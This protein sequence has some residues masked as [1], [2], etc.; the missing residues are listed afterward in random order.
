MKRALV[1]LAASLVVSGCAHHVEYTLKESDRWQGQKVSAIVY[2]KPFVDLSPYLTTPEEEIGE[3]VWRTN[4][5]KGYA[6]T[7]LTAEVTAALVKHLN[8]S[9]LL[10]HAVATTETNA[11][12]VLSGTLARFETRARVNTKA[13][14]IQAVS[15]GFGL[16]GALAGSATTSSMKSLIKTEVHIE[17]A[18][19]SDPAGKILWKNSIVVSNQWEDGFMA[20]NETVV[21]SHCN[22]ALKQAFAQLINQ[23]GS[24]I[25]TNPPPASKD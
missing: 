6:Q 5:R 2:V 22:D 1:I 7:N 15:G 13:E 18:T 9:G 16:I 12:L 17:A 19:L 8:Y 14:T 25:A 24:S 21:F 23:I 4:H 3:E 10:T 20:A 11:D